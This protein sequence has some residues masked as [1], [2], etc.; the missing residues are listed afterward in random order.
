MKIGKY[1]FLFLQSEIRRLIMIPPNI[2]GWDRRR[3]EGSRKW[4]IH[5][6]GREK[7]RILLSGFHRIDGMEC[8]T[9]NKFKY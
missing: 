2:N 1:V 6:F 4:K 9:N 5:E 7:V 3:R 8:V